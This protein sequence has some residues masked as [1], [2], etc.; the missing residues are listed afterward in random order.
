MVK[1]KGCFLDN[2]CIQKRV[3]ILYSLDTISIITLKS[4]L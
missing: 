1:K 2:L 4:V 3:Y